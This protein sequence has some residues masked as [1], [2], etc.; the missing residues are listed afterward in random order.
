[1][2]RVEIT[3]EGRPLQARLGETVASSLIAAGE[4]HFRTSPRGE[5]R[6][7]FCGMG[8]CQE[9]LVEIDGWPSQRA[10]MTKIGGPMVVKRQRAPVPLPDEHR[11]AGRPRPETLAP[12]VLVV[13]GGAGGLAAAANAARAGASVVL[14]DER[15]ALG[16]Q[17]Y[18][19]PAFPARDDAQFAGGRALIAEAE[20]AG[21]R[22]LKGALAWG[23]FEPL[24]LMLLHE[25]AS[26][27][28]RPKRLIVATGAY[29]RGLPVPGW[30]LPGVMTTGAAQTLW[31]SYGVLPGR[32]VLVAGNGPL[33]LQVAL[34]LA[35]AG[36]EIVAVAELSPRPGLA[37]AG[38]FARM[39]LSSPG[40]LLKGGLMLAKLARCG[41]PVRHSRVLRAV[42][43][44]DN[45]LVATL[46]P[47]PGGSGAPVE[48]EVDVVC[49]GYGFLPQNELLRA[50]GCRHGFDAA[51]GQLAT[52]R[53]G[54]CR[55]SVEAVYAIGD[56][57]GL[58]GAPAA[59]AEG[60]IAGSAAARSLGLS[61][62]PDASAARAELA[63]HRKFQAALWRVFSAPGP[64][65][66]LAT[67]DTIVCRCEELTRADIEAGL[68]AD[69][70]LIGSLK[71]L[72]RVGM[73]AC[74]GRYCGPLVAGLLAERCGGT[75]D[76]MSFWAPRP[77]AKPVAI[78]DIADAQPTTASASISTS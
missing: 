53:D 56:C 5:P 40:L 62:A 2:K 63:R 47:W 52:M 65:L 71:R 18:K 78:A 22:F 27:V 20:A 76:G 13:G 57:T 48:C 31:R 58:G 42:S 72:T 37:Q 64:A 16:G 10:C 4:R 39:A 26:I 41:I 50:L 33:N 45:G 25:G 9:C 73:G 11:L 36:A 54:D 15:P 61:G 38:D 30:T 7:L 69:P 75:L 68:A 44:G 17:F 77:P 19:Q 59:V 49:M 3:F 6:G 21:V 46:G 14:A 8:V 29:E 51:R 34:E 67:P 60:R 43:R 70:R 28:A 12:D 55:T 23:A 66:E 35:T 1:M 32:R 24:E 74:Q